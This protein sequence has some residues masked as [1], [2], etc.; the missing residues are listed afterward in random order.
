MGIK[1][2]WAVTQHFR[3]FDLILVAGNL[4]E[5]ITKIQNTCRNV[6]PHQHTIPIRKW[7]LLFHTLR[8]Y[9]IKLMQIW[10]PKYPYRNAFKWPSTDWWPDL[11]P[12]FFKAQFHVQFLQ[13]KQW[14]KQIPSLLPHSYSGSFLPGAQLQLWKHTR[15]R[16]NNSPK[17]Q[18]NLCKKRLF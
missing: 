7:N 14:L 11:S 18:R 6:S 9:N 3:S 10:K 2:S 16:S 5:T 8:D 17:L 4:I 1:V 15:T 12:P 13:E